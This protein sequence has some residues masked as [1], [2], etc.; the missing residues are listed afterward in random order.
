[1]SQTTELEEPSAPR[2]VLRTVTPGSKPR[3]DMEMDAI[4][5]GVFLGMVILL[6]PLLPF[7][8][9]LWA[10]T[11]ALDYLASQRGE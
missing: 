10:F 9:V 7:L 8:V 4:G 1:M 2:K 6:V 3:P 5:W 11:K